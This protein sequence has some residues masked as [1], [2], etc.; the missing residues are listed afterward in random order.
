MR[1][2]P[3]PPPH[4][5][6]SRCVGR[7]QDNLNSL[8]LSMYK[9][10]KGWGRGGDGKG[11][12]R[13]SVRASASW[14]RGG[15]CSDRPWCCRTCYRQPSAWCTC[16]CTSTSSAGSSNRGGGW[17]P[18]R[19]RPV[20]GVHRSHVVVGL[21]VLVVDHWVTHATLEVPAYAKTRGA[22]GVG[23]GGGGDT[24]RVRHS[25]APSQNSRRCV[26]GST[27]TVR[28]SKTKASVPPKQ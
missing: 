27:A 24:H 1:P 17:Q 19:P 7:P 28:V 5:V 12:G 15:C 18:Q 9:G 3:P 22:R 21:K 8:L 6:N 10:C 25:T 20:F 11:G 2:H 16:T 13:V 23:V 26:C 4:F 14:P